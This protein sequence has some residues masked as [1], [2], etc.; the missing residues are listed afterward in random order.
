MHREIDV[1]PSNAFSLSESICSRCWCVCVYLV[2]L[3]K[4]SFLLHFLIRV[5]KRKTVLFIGTSRYR[6]KM[7]VFLLYIV[8]IYY[9]IEKIYEKW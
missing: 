5:F 3:Q 4:M 7:N 6:R 2:I 9:Y 1:S 8:R